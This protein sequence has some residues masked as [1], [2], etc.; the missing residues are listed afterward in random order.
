MKALIF[1]LFTFVTALASAATD[2]PDYSIAD[3]SSHSESSMSL[4]PVQSESELEAFQM[5]SGSLVEGFPAI[6][7][8]THGELSMNKDEINLNVTVNLDCPP[9]QMCPA[10]IPAPIAIKMFVS[11]VNQRS[12]YQEIV[13]ETIESHPYGLEQHKVIVKD[14]R[15][16]KLDSLCP[17]LLPPILGVEYTSQFTSNMNYGVQ[18]KKAI[19]QFKSLTNQ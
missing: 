17:L 19:F 14:Y 12:C 3:Q 11:E 6:E 18:T 7:V 9:M 13:A 10:Y 15:K 5:I 2:M 4:L 8:P 1:S 16:V